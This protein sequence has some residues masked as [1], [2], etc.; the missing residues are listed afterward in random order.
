MCKQKYHFYSKEI[1]KCLYKSVIYRKKN[2]DILEKNKLLKN[3]NKKK[4][5]S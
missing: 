2:L 1:T 3:I 5:R 4:L